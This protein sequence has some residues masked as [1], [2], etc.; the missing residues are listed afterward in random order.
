MNLTTTKKA[1]LPTP[2]KDSALRWAQDNPSLTPKWDFAYS[3]ETTVAWQLKVIARC[4]AADD[5]PG[6]A[7][8]LDEIER[9]LK[10]ARDWIADGDGGCS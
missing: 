3:L 7:E 5:L 8:S 9:A 10:K 4:K 1:P 2:S 6:A